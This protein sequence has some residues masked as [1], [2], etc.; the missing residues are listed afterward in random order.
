MT[1]L[2]IALALAVA[3]SPGPRQITMTG[4]ARIAFKPNRVTANFQLNTTHRNEAGARAL[5]EEKTSAFIKACVAAGASQGDII[6][7]AVG[8]SPQ[9]RGNE[10]TGAMA[11]RSIAVTVADLSHVDDV[12][13]AAVRS[14]GIPIG[15]VSITHTDRIRYE[16]EARTAAAKDAHSRA[17]NVLGA[18]GA[19]VGLPISV[20]DRTPVMAVVDGGGF[21]TPAQGPVVTTFGSRDLVINASVTVIFDIEPPK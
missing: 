18:L 9:Y 8:A 17:E 2:L 14:G 1:P 7:L 21:V 20:T 11:A 3:P 12:L 6:P 13:T 10:V 16:D 19:R 15:S 4:E 5:L